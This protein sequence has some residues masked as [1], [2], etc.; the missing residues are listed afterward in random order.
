M[1][2]ERNASVSSLIAI[3]IREFFTLLDSI[4]DEQTEIRLQVEDD[5]G[6]LRVWVGNLGAHRKQTDRLSLDYRL[7]EAP[8]LHQEVR[9]HINDISEA[10]QG[11]IQHHYIRYFNGC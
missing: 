10:V 2:S 11:G 3:C 7:R 9:N 5:L 4:P 8:D 1:N 6:R